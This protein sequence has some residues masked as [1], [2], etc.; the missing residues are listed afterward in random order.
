[1]FKFLLVGTLISVIVYII[2][3]LGYAHGNQDGQNGI[4]KHPDT[5]DRWF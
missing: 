4:N 1:M 5:Q 3:L 2:Y